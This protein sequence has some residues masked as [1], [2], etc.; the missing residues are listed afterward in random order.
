MQNIVRSAS[1]IVFI[2]LAVTACAGFLVRLLEAKD[3]MLLVGM[4]PQLS[5]QNRPTVITSKPANGRRSGDKVFYSFA[6]GS[7]KRVFG[8]LDFKVPR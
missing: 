1:K 8:F 7:G 2:M 3:F 4:A 6:A 5:P